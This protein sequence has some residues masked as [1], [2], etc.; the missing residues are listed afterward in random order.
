MQTFSKNER[1]SGQK[2]IDLLF[3]E[4]RSF[5][6]FP[7][8]M[9]WMEYEF[10][11]AP[12]I[13]ILITVS[14]KSFKKAVDRNLIRRRIREAYRK[15]KTELYD[16]LGQQ[17]VQCAVVLIYTANTILTFKEIE[18]KIILLLHRFQTE[19]EKVIR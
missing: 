10:G 13:K 2:I 4:G 11:D 8:R 7:Y 14:K 16:F 6:L 15:H 12:Q 5:V 3:S 1:L 18:E 19:Y 17:K 9:I